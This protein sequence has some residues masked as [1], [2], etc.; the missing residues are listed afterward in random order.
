VNEK[1]ENMEW[2]NCITFYFSNKLSIGEGGD[3][4]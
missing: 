2:I 4:L 3:D 1:V